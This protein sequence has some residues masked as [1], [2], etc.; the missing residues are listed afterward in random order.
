LTFISVMMSVF[1]L[2]HFLEIFSLM[3]LASLKGSPHFKSFLLCQLYSSVGVIFG[4][5]SF[6]DVIYFLLRSRTRG[7]AATAR[8]QFIE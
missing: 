6:T 2:I 5:I 8:H 7:N 3:K 1:V 4:Y